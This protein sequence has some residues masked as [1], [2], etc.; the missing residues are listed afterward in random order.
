M[1]YDANYLKVLPDYV[2]NSYVDDCDDAKVKSRDEPVTSLYE[3]PQLSETTDGQHQ[4][5]HYQRV[6]TSRRLPGN[7]TSDCTYDEIVDI[8]SP[9]PP[10]PGWSAVFSLNCYVVAYCFMSTP[11][12]TQNDKKNNQNRCRESP[13]T[14]QCVC[15]RGS[16]DP[17]VEA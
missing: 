6:I 9:P 11:V 12:V 4:R 15:S 1:T 10:R 8:P 13:F 2:S 16:S 17:A 3:R 5:T 14:A 7:V